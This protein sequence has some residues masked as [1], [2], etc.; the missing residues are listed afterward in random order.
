[1]VSGKLLTHCVKHPRTTPDLPTSKFCTFDCR[2]PNSAKVRV[3]QADPLSYDRN[4]LI[5]HR[6]FL[7]IHILERA[8]LGLAGGCVLSAVFLAAFF[9]VSAVHVSAL[10]MT[11]GALGL[12]CAAGVAWGIIRRPPLLYVAIETDRQL[13][14]NDLLSTA[15][16]CGGTDADEWCSAVREE[17]ARRCRGIALHAVEARQLGTGAWGGIVL[18]AM[19]VITAALFLGSSSG[20]QV[21]AGIAPSGDERKPGLVAPPDHPLLALSRGDRAAPVEHDDPDNGPPVEHPTPPSGPADKAATAN[22]TTAEPDTSS[23]Q[24]HS[25][26][27]GSGSSETHPPDRPKASQA[28]DAVAPMPATPRSSGSAT[29]SRPA[30]EETASRVTVLEKCRRA[31]SFRAWSIRGPCAG[32]Q[33]PPVANSILGRGRSACPSGSGHGRDSPSIPRD[34]APIF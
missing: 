15:L 17:A 33:C 11:A 9:F 4:L 25:A 18:S 29:L 34:G 12:G 31:S 16:S 14:W 3:M 13:G 20:M 23:G 32:T 5:L 26:G 6:R 8:G 10:S 22:S 27:A 7:R 24:S 19:A 28:G 2:Y 30:T 21:S 1:M